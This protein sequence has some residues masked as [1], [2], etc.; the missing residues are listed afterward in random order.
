MSLLIEISLR[1]ILQD[2]VSHLLSPLL[3]STLLLLD[4]WLKVW[5][6]VIHIVEPVTLLDWLLSYVLS[7]SLSVV[8]PAVSRPCCLRVL[9]CRQLF[10]LGSCDVRIE[11]QGCFGIDSLGTTH[12]HCNEVF[13]AIRSTAGLDRIIMKIFS[14]GR[15]GVLLELGC[16]QADSW[17][18]EEVLQSWGLLIDRGDS[19]VPRLLPLASADLVYPEFLLRLPRLQV[20]WRVTLERH[21]I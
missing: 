20:E 6:D 11:D 4:S 12:F 7:L 13:L 19:E 9:E 5:E 17:L 15:R 10:D 8:V 2:A 1:G 3:M 14:E 18:R 16:L 21:Y